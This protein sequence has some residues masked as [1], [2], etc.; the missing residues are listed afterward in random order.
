[1]CA[2]RSFWVQVNKSSDGSRHNTSECSLLRKPIASLYF[3][4]KSNL[5]HGTSHIS[6]ATMNHSGNAWK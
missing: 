2:L 6:P 3:G 4:Y 5:T 1:M